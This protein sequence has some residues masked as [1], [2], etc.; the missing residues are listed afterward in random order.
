[1]GLSGLGKG[2]KGESRREG[3]RVETN[4][5]ENRGKEKGRG[6]K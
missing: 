4:E 5:D 1:M 2:G 3:G 6:E